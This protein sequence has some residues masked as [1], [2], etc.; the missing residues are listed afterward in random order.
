MVFRNI[1]YVKTPDE[2]TGMKPEDVPNTDAGWSGIESDLQFAIDNLGATPYNGEPGRATKYAAMAV[3]ANAL[4]HQKKYADA[5]TLL[6]G[7]INSGKYSLVSNYYD[8]YN[9]TTE[10]NKESIF[11]IQAQTTGTNLSSM[12]VAG[13]S[14][15]Q[16]GPAAIGWGFYQPSEVLFESFQVTTNGLPV[17]DIDKREA[18]AND[19][20]VLSN[21]EFHPTDHLLDPRVDWTHPLAAELIFWVGVFVPVRPGIREH[22]K[23]RPVHDQEIY[24]PVCQQIVANQR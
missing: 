4:L 10:N 8:N 1:P 13:P 5:K 2:L 3:K 21:A 18:L 7:I 23:W 6:D 11:E 14:M 17:L 20:K 22:G 9:E 24:A 15:H 12:L 19:M 16:A